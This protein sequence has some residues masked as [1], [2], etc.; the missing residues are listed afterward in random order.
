MQ[1]NIAEKYI[2]LIGEQKLW[3]PLNGYSPFIQGSEWNTKKYF[4]K[5][6]S[7]KLRYHWIMLINKNESMML[8][9]ED[10]VHLVASEFFQ[11]YLK[12][13]K[14]LEERSE[15]FYSSIFE[16]DKIYLKTSHDFIEKN[17]FKV[18]SS[19]CEKLCF[20]I[21]DANAATYA[22][23]FFE[24]EFCWDE[25]IKS[26]FKITR[27]DFD[28]VWD[29]A[30]HPVEGSFDKQ[31]M[32]HILNLFAEKKSWLEIVE[33]CQYFYT[34]YRDAKSLLEVE[35]RLKEQF[36]HFNNKKLALKEIEKEEYE[37][38]GKKEKY[39]KWYGDLNKNQ[40][41][42]ADYLQS[43]IIIRD[44]RKNFFNKCI[45]IW[46]RVA[47]KMFKEAGISEKYIIYYTFREMQ[48]GLEYLKENREKIMQ[49]ENGFFELIPYD[50]DI[51]MKNISSD[52][53]IKFKKILME[54]YLNGHKSGN[55]KATIKGNIGA[56]GKISGKV[57]VIIDINK[58]NDFKDGEILVTGMTRP[59][60]VPLMKK[61]S[62]IITD[63][64]GVT[65]HA[66]IVARELKKPC[67]IGTK[68]ATQVLKD[69]D[70]VE[71]DADKGVVKIIKR[72][73]DSE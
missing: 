61:A 25:I 11:A 5:Y 32:M 7:D 71:V 66:A 54:F 1:N 56:P 46:W 3:P 49:R 64:G 21:W 51:E 27:E 20:L 34:S 62:A 4:G 63:E 55:A 40:K 53:F 29:K 48:K 13:P 59:E 2:K 57:R 60:F 9:P 18:L 28:A 45:T 37:G 52:D 38:R 19:I 26:E 30:I 33:E 36:G 68:I 70:L 12:N 14:I 44:R 15:Y 39:A 6:F 16:V 42:V 73:K 31:Q 67:I 41:I 10:G 72:A 65:C 22:S 8:V 35:K 69:G 24:K 23:I 47:Q 43:I 17:N 58:G 50:E